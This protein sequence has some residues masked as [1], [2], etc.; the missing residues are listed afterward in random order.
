MKCEVVPA[1]S[2]GKKRNFPSSSVL[3]KVYINTKHTWLVRVTNG[4]G[5]REAKTGDLLVTLSRQKGTIRRGGGQ[6]SG[7][8]GETSTTTSRCDAREK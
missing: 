6:R 5:G 4:L 1:I 7:T 2:R 3:E 8:Q